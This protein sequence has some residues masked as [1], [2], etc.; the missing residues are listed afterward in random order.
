LIRSVKFAE[1]EASGRVTGTEKLGDRTC[2][3]VEMRTPKLVRQLY[4]DAQSGLLYKTH[5]E[6]SVAS[7]GISPAETVFED[8]RAVNGV[9]VPFST[10]GITT[11]DRVRT[12]IAEMHV[13]VPIDEA[14]FKPPV[15]AGAGK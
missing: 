13:N 8:Y 4:F 1:V 2:T 7:F 9:N 10:I 14:R 5:V 3:V 6:T 15:T 12:D 11:A